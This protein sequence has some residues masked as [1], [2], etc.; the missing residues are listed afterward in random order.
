[1]LAVDVLD[2]I[3]YLA[4]RRDYTLEELQQIY[5]EKVLEKKMII[6]NGKHVFITGLTGFLGR[7]IG[8]R[9]LQQ[10][11]H[12]IALVRARGVKEANERAK[13]ALRIVGPI[14]DFENRVNAVPGDLTIGIPDIDEPIDKVWHC[15]GSISFAIT[16]RKDNYK[17]NV[18]GT[19]IL[20]EWSLM[21]GAEDVYYINTAYRC[22]KM[23]GEIPEDLDEDE[24]IK[25]GFWNPYE[26]TKFF[27]GSRLQYWSQIFEIPVT[28]FCPTIVI[29]DSENSKN[30]SESGY[31]KYM[32]GMQYIRDMA[33]DELGNGDYV[34]V[35]FRVVVEPVPVNMMCVDYASGLMVKLASHP[36]SRNKTFHI[37]NPNPPDALWWH[38]KSAEA[39]GLKGLQFVNKKQ[40]MREKSHNGFIRKAELTF[41]RINKP[42]LPYVNRDLNFRMDN[43]KEVLG[44]VPEHPEVNEELI[45]KLLERYKRK[46]H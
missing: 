32:Q 26:E 13:S 27:A 40:F 38:E 16:D 45:R 28:E 5:Q 3:N 39:I 1:M 21:K 20:L 36:E 46:T 33:A 10:G 43:V 37:A 6:G 29:G 2:E 34:K 25:R 41:Y 8:Y 44:Y 18:R 30:S 19:E 31:I 7:N 42:Y 11:Y 23:T 14:G 12:L 15:A 9:L 24:V 35:P 22:G 4:Q 17:I